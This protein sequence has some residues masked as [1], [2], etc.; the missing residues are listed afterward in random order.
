MEHHHQAGGGGESE[1]RYP[2]GAP[3]EGT[4][5]ILRRYSAGEISGGKP[6]SASGRRRRSMMFSRASLPPRFRFPSQRL[7]SLPVRL[8]RC[9]RST[10][11][12][13]P[14]YAAEPIDDL[15]WR[16]PHDGRDPALGA[17]RLERLAVLL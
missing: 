14:G 5:T 4:M 17:Q 6:P 13:C 8:R 12:M 7:R 15:W 10:A 16:D 1:P 2:G 3:D 11:R 9:G